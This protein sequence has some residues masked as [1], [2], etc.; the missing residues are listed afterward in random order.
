MS[1]NGFYTTI[2]HT[3]YQYTYPFFNVKKTVNSNL[4]LYWEEAHLQEMF[5]SVPKRQKKWIY[6]KNSRSK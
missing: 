1:V 3:I 4:P 2:H 5:N 6:C